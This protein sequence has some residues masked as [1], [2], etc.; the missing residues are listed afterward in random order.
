[1]IS[2]GEKNK[3]RRRYQQFLK[4]HDVCLKTVSLED[5]V[6]S[7]SYAEFAMFFVLSVK[8][9]ETMTIKFTSPPAEFMG[10]FYEKQQRV[11]EWHRRASKRARLR[12][13]SSCS[14]ARPHLR[15]RSVEYLDLTIP[16]TC[17]C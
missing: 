12:L 5:Y 3:W 15:K 9:L 13:S 17:G 4:D 1:M 16:F 6:R 7:G 14:H 8:D 2:H 11:L 10:V